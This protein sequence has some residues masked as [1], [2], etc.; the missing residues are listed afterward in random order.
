[1]RIAFTYLPNIWLRRTELTA[2][3]CIVTCPFLYSDHPTVIA[4]LYS[5]SVTFAGHFDPS[6]RLYVLV[7][8]IHDM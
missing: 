6:L 2:M 1:M 3:T 7:H 8:D 5:I 4:R